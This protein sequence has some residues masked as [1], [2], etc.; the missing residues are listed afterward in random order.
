MFVSFVCALNDV[1]VGVYFCA[2]MSVIVCARVSRCM[3][4]CANVLMWCVLVHGYMCV[5]NYKYVGVFIN[6]LMHGCVN[7]LM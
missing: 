1:C 5:G 3:H 2:C 4:G 7:I 6:V